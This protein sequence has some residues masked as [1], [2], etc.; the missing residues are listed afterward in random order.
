MENIAEMRIPGGYIFANGSN[1]RTVMDAIGNPPSNQEVGLFAPETFNWFVVFEFSEIGFVKDDEKNSFDFEAML[2]SMRKATESSNKFRREKG[3]PGLHI[4]DW[5]TK[6]HYDEITHNLEWAVRAKDDYGELI[7]N[8]NTRVL[9][10]KGVMKVTLVVEQEQMEIVL[11]T[12]KR[13]MDGFEFQAGNK[14]AEFRKG[15]KVAQYGL[16]GLIVGGAAAVAVKSGL[17]KWLWK[18]ILVA[19]AG[20]GALIKRL[21]GKK[22]NVES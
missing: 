22:S 5:E 13:H 21:F 3:F 11:P 18:I 8:H 16:T 19:I 1:T 6:P 7:L 12:F 15:D 4:I 10:R 2:E 9:G 20:I 17:A 14:Y